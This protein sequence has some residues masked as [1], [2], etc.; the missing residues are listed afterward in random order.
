MTEGA[1]GE[2]HRRPTWIG[3]WG[4]QDFARFEV[5]ADRVE[6]DARNTRDR[7]RPRRAYRR[8][9][10]R[11]PEKQGALLVRFRLKE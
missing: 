1:R 3:R 2:E 4:Y 5:R 6:D 7:G 8:A 11:R 9:R 10:T